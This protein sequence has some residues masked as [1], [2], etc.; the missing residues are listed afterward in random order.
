MK[1]F[2]IAVFCGAFLLGSVAKAPAIDFKIM[3][4]WLVGLGLADTKLIHKKRIGNREYKS[5]DDQFSA[6]QRLRIQFDAVASESLSGALYF[7]IGNQYWGQ[8]SSGGALGADGNNVIK[9]RRAYMDWALPEAPLSVRMGIQDFILPHTAGGTAVMYTDAAGITASY[10]LNENVAITAAWVRPLN[11][12]FTGKK[13]HGGQVYYDNPSE[14]G[15]LDN[16]DLF[17]L[18]LPVKLDGYTFTPWLMYGM[19]GAN[20]M[21][22]IYKLNGIST[23][24]SDI[25]DGNLNYSLYPYPGI[26]GRD[27]VGA[28]QK[29]MASCGG[30]DCQS[31]LQPWSPGILSLI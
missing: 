14:A 22:G 26:A 13:Y 24:R 4:E 18:I 1:K 19:K 27:R 30:Q 15:Y 28:L 9:I 20:T 8:A 31:A 3:G 11:D 17:A 23:A 12:N 29:L 6:L 16:L 7:E 21:D 5:T 2:W 10:E 25:A